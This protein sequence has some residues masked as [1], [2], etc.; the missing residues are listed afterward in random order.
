MILVVATICLRVDLLTLECKTE[1]VRVEPTPVAC[2]EMLA[3]V[4][5]WLRETHSPEWVAVA[6]KNGPLY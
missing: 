1:V 3:P 5:K 2:I 6:C 4:E